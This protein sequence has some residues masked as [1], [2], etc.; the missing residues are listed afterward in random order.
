[1]LQHGSQFITNKVS[2]AKNL[3]EKGP[4]DQLDGYE[5]INSSVVLRVAACHRTVAPP[6]GKAFNNWRPLLYPIICLMQN[7]FSSK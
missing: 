5:Q 2:R 6:V 1:M 3:K 4:T 7:S